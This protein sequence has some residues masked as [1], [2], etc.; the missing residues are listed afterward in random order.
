MNRQARLA[1]WRVRYF[2]IWIG[3]AFSLFGSRA[4]QFALVWWLTQLTGSA[5][6]L[7]TATLVALLPEIL[8]S[9]IAGAYVDRWDRR[10]VI[11]ISDVAVAISSLWLAY[12]FW[13]DAAEVW[14]IYLIMFT[15]SVA[16]SFQAP[17]FLASTSLMVPKEHLTR[18]AGLNQILQGGLS[19]AGP[20]LGAFLMGLLSIS[21]IMMIDVG[22]AAFA[23][24]PL[25]FVKI[26]Q[27]DRDAKSFQVNSIWQDLREGLRYIAGWPALLILVGVVMILRTAIAPAFSLLPLLVSDYFQGDAAQLGLLEAISGIGMIIGGLLLSIWGGFKRRIFTTILGLIV[28]GFSLVFLGLTPAA[29]FVMALVSVFVIGLTIPLIDGPLMAIFQASVRPELQGRVFTLLGSMVGVISIFSLALAGPVSDWLGLQFWY[30]TAG[31]FC[32]VMGIALFFIPTV[33]NIEEEGHP[34]D[35]R[36][37]SLRT[38]EDI[39]QG[40]GEK[41]AGD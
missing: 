25:L 21:A 27:P 16:G 5:T 13:I 33:V 12:L 11:I 20:P 1:D 23:I 32:A 31:I 40:V 15:R 17:A 10:M 36:P 18:V 34:V 22:T 30:L 6:V 26:P 3:Q 9:P 4:A 37:D 2:S 35:N 7:A 38:P 29:L 19:I 24:L 14:H 41:L 28:L 39:E 8:I